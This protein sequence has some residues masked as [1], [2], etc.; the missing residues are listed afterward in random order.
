MNAI[1]T[2]TQAAQQSINEMTARVYG[3]NPVCNPSALHVTTKIMLCAIQVALTAK[4]DKLARQAIWN[5]VQNAQ[6]ARHAARPFLGEP[7]DGTF[8]TQM[9]ELTI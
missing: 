1:L 8:K 5:A 7:F 3:P 4:T 6:H 2:Q 9:G